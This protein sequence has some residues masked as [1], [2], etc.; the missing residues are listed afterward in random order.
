M[1]STLCSSGGWIL[2]LPLAWPKGV[3]TRGPHQWIGAI[4]ETLDHSCATELQAQLMQGSSFAASVRP[5]PDFLA[6]LAGELEPFA[7]GTAAMPVKAVERMIGRAGRL[8]YLIPGCR[9]FVS[10]LFA[11]FAAT[12]TGEDH[13]AQ[14]DFLP[15]SRFAP[16]ARWIHSL[17]RPRPDQVD[18]FPLQHVI[19]HAPP[20]ISL[21]TAAVVYFDASLWGGGAVLYRENLPEAYFE[22]E[23]AQ[24]DLSPIGLLSG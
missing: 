20:R 12:K 23:W 3:A 2:G 17:I 9:P 8:A 15:V 4:F 11:A 10:S 16:A 18:E 19:V 1:H 24:V 14:L 21:T 22:V 5:P 6:E 13:D 7:F